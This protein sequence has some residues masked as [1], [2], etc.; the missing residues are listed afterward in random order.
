MALCLHR[1]AGGCRPGQNPEIKGVFNALFFGD[2]ADIVAV[3][4]GG[5]PHMV[6]IEHGLD[7]FC[8]R[9]AGR[10]HHGLRI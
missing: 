8:H 3:I 1:T 9:S 5:D 7:M 2:L 6:K 10:F 4:D